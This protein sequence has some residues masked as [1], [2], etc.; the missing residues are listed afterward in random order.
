LLLKLVT[1]MR[2]VYLTIG[3]VFGL[4]L[5]ASFSALIPLFWLGLLGVAVLIAGYGRSSRWPWFFFAF[6][7]LAFAGF[8]YQL[9][10]QTSALALYNDIGSAT[11]E[12]LVVAE[13][14]IRDDRILIRLE[15]ERIIFGAEEHETSGL[16]LVTAPR[17]LELAYGDRLL[18]TGRIAIPAEYDTFSYAD[19]LAQQ[20]VFSLMT[21]ASV[22][23][24]AQGEGNFFYQNLLGFKAKL[25]GI[26]AR[27]LPEPEAALL[28]GILLGNERGIDKDLA[29]AFTRVGAAHIIA[30]SGFNMALISS[31]VQ[32]FF[33]RFIKREW[34]AVMLGVFV[35]AL[36]TLLVGA[37]TAVVRAAI[38]S[39]MLVIAP[40]FKRKTYVPASLCFVALLLSLQNPFVLWDISFQLSFFAVLGLAL[41]AEPFQTRFYRLLNALF[42]RRFV[43]AIAAVTN[44]PIVLSLAALSLTLPLTIL[45][46]Q[47]FSLVML[48]VNLLILPVQA[49]LLILGGLALMLALVFPPLAQILFWLD[50]LLLMWTIAIVRLFGALP[51]ADTNFTLDYRLI[52]FSIACIIGGAIVN[53][54]KPLWA[55]RVVITLRRQPIFNALLFSGL[56]IISLMLLIYLSR[57]DGK[58]H[59]WWIDVG[60]SNAVLIQSPGGTQILVDGGHFPSRLLTALG[61]RMPFYDRRIELVIISQPDEWD[62]SALTAVLNRYESPLIL[63]NGQPNQ[64]DSYQLL[65]NAMSASQVLVVRA[66]YE[67]RFSDGTILEILHPQSEPALNEAMNDHSLVIRLRYGERSFLL[68][69]DISPE[70]QAAMLE[71][72]FWPLAEM[73]QLPQHGAARSLDDEFLLAV[74]PQAIVLQAD[75]ANRR[76][77]PSEDSLA[78][79]GN[80]PLFR[81]DEDGTLHFWTDGKSLWAVGTR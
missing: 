42:P 69:S 77:E 4:L 48:L 41:F 8:R 21:N 13:P 33:G 46:F 74:Q 43:P 34:L 28:T 11:I 52:W 78:A 76:G 45:Y 37:N 22:E 14:D 2:L 30:I 80:L 7:A 32:K 65:E 73:M 51:Y 61:D 79:V 9:L 55:R 71:A 56:G 35:L 81:T 54:T 50:M 60:H 66:G 39:S 31:V 57:P 58:L 59:L 44:E 1:F 17:S 63:T 24:V 6:V 67:I 26:I 68:S 23:I 29:D 72:G 36:Y 40:L 38:M 62:S 12:G 47:R 10:P 18:V 49:W 3:W 64:S 75:R 16:I 15:A 19:Y 20:G 70:G 27:N 5:A 53:A 25:Q